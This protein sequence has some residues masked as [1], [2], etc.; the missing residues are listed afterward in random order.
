MLLSERLIFFGAS[1]TAQAAPNGYFDLVRKDIE[2]HGGSAYRFAF[3][4]CH[5]DDAGFHK[6]SELTSAEG[7]CCIIEWNT[8]G[9]SRFD[10]SK[11]AVIFDYLLNHQIYPIILILPHDR[12]LRVN[13][14]AELQMK[15]ISEDFGLP[16]L[17]LRNDFSGESLWRDN[18]HTTP[19]GAI[20]YANRIS[21]FLRE[22]HRP[23]DS[24]ILK[25]AHS[26]RQ[27]RQ[28]V[29]VA[30]RTIPH[31]FALQEGEQLTIEFERQLQ[32]S[33]LLFDLTIGPDSP[34]LDLQVD[35][36]HQQQISIW[37]PWCHYDRRKIVSILGESTF[38][39]TG[40]SGK[41][42]LSIS[43]VAPNYSSCRREKFN[44][45]GPRN[46]RV[47]NILT[48]NFNVRALHAVAV[49]GST[50]LLLKQ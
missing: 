44:Y 17:D 35:N 41:L 37:D 43:K 27:D 10:P 7:N 16:L 4:S 40:D 30:F 14:D 8:T 9:L 19:E 25:L 13:R 6:A 33:E 34:I 11:L 15:E 49:N 18:V 45:T 31:E 36:G 26:W 38:R 48:A 21:K 5:L 23:S 20:D 28:P 42:M 39:R 32:L 12:N 22:T 29:A 2:A 47:H 1:V 3:G 24:E 46:L 50:R